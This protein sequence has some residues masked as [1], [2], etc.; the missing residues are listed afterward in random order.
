M[1]KAQRRNKLKSAPFPPDWRRTL[2][3]LFPLYTRLPEEDR[4]EL[5]GHVQ[6]FLAEKKFEGCGGLEITDEMKVCI[7]PQA[8]LLLLRRDT[9]FLIGDFEGLAGQCSVR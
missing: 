1:W 5:R 4:R 3:R 6:V 2:E 8:C 7:A 9:D